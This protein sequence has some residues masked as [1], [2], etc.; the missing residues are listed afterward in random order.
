MIFNL[1]FLFFIVRLFLIYNFLEPSFYLYLIF[2]PHLQLIFDLTISYILNSLS[3]NKIPRFK[4][5][6]K[7]INFFDF[8]FIFH[9]INSYDFINH[10]QFINSC[11]LINFYLLTNFYHPRNTYYSHLYHKSPKKTKKIR[12]PKPPYLYL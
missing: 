8:P 11:H 10:C 3:P 4:F 12:R 6:F 1:Y 9:L 7:L 2:Y 5:N